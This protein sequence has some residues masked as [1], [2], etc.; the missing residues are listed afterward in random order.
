V[1]ILLH[2]LGASKPWIKCKVAGR[3]LGTGWL[4][5]AGHSGQLGPFGIAL[6]HSYRQ[7]TSRSTPSRMLSTQA[8]VSHGV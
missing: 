8:P 7:K 2:P 4:L 1:V 6:G 5:V 3:Y